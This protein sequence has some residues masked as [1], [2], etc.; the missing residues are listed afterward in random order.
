MNFVVQT[1]FHRIPG[2]RY[3]LVRTRIEAALSNGVPIEVYDDGFE[4]Q[5]FEKRDVAERVRGEEIAKARAAGEIIYGLTDFLYLEAQTVADYVFPG[6]HALAHFR[7]LPQ[8]ERT[9][10]RI[11]YVEE[12][13]CPARELRLAEAA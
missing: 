7:S 13:V 6:P 3:R 12:V 4:T 1:Y 2:I 8:E 11:R 5:Y 9:A 10:L